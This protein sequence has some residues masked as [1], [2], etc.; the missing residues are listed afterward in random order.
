MKTP[1]LIAALCLTLSIGSPSLAQDAVSNAIKARQAQMLL[2]GFNLGQLG[3]MAKGAV[4]YN[5]DV[6]NAAA[7]NLVHLTSLNGQSMW[8]ADSD[9]MS[10]DNTRALP[11]IWEN[12]ADVGAKTS[13]VAEA[14]LAMQA[15][16]GSGLDGVR[17]AIGDL[18][19]ACGA[20][21]KIYR[22][23]KN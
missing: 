23:P 5:A 6:A 11:A 14:A 18:G 20:C 19:A 22:A 8:I 7:A 16:A 21:H 10:A 1:S 13:A 15:A 2:Y 3:A 4:P 9:D 17:G 12:L